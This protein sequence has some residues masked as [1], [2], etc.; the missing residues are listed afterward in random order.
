MFS[1]IVLFSL[2]LPLQV[3]GQNVV[4]V[5]HRQVVNMIR[6]GGNSLMVKVVM[7][8]R[9]PDMEEGS[10]KKSKSLVVEGWRGGRVYGWAGWA[11][12][13][14][15]DLLLSFSCSPPAEQEA[16][17]PGHCPQVQVHDLRAGGDG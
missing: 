5:G 17:H 3:N 9:N 13:R 11:S 4:K 7:V 6:Q 16:E 1:S 8:T 2:L 15:T 12:S 10:R 14:H